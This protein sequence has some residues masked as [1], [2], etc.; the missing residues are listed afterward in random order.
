[1]TRNRTP[2][3][4]EKSTPGVAGRY[5]PTGEGEKALLAVILQEKK[6]HAPKRLILGEQKGEGGERG[7]DLRRK[8]KR[9]TSFFGKRE[10]R[11]PSKA[12]K[13]GALSQG[14]GGGGTNPCRGIK[15][16]K[17]LLKYPSEESVSGSDL[18][19]GESKKRLYNFADW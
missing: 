19:G 5:E 7:L 1:M 10:I 6:N 15:K 16:K 17:G 12:P 3:K 8:R 14:G 18:V 13:E 9:K 11:S 4:R 2:E